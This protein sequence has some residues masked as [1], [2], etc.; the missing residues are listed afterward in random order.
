MARG[1]RI[2]TYNLHGYNMGLGCLSDLC[3][4]NDI[5]AVQ[6][7]WL[8]KNKLHQLSTVNSNFAA[9]GISSMNEATE[10][11]IIRGRPFGGV[12]FFLWR[13]DLANRIKILH[14]GVAGLV[15]LCQ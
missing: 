10:E 5:V 12:G 13:K 6:E 14:S 2:A 11:K 4:R 1:L 8:P 9:Y 7:H 3:D 15:L